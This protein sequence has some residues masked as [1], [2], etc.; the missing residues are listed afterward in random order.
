MAYG[1]YLSWRRKD[2]RSTVANDLARILGYNYDTILAMLIRWKAFENW[3]LYE[4]NHRPV[5]IEEIAGL[6]QEALN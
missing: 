4:V 5:N 1:D 3:T 2:L 6:V